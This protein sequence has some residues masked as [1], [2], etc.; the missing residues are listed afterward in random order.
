M[1]A[2]REIRHEVAMASLEAV[3]KEAAKVV[4]RELCQGVIA[5]EA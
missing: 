3:A 2:L 1:A 5:C 4:V